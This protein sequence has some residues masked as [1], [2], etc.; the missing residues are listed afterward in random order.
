[1][2]IQ[3]QAVQ[4]AFE[5][6]LAGHRLVLESGIEGSPRKIQVNLQTVEGGLVQ[7]RTVVMEGNHTIP[8]NTATETEQEALLKFRQ[9]VQIVVEKFGVQLVNLTA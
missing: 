4:E 5:R 2:P 3:K 1:M 6:L 9:G 7:A 8:I